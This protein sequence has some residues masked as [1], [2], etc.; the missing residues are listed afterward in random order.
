MAN[1]NP[2]NI[3]AFWV[4]T[5]KKSGE[6]YFSGYFEVDGQKVPCSLFKSKYH[7]K[8]NPKSV[9]LRV[10]RQTEQ[11]QQQTVKVDND[12]HDDMFDLV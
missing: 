2:D 1:D 6:T 11:P 4:K 10:I 8:K 3:G 12:N 7:D 5:S 9:A